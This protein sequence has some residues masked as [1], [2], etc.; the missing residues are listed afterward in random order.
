MSIV[1][2]S[3]FFEHFLRQADGQDLRRPVVL[4]LCYE[5]RQARAVYR[6][7]TGQRMPAPDAGPLPDGQE[8]AVVLVAEAAQVAPLLREHA[9]PGGA[10]A[11]ETLEEEEVASD[12]FGVILRRTGLEVGCFNR[13]GGGAG[14]AG[15]PA[16]GTP[17]RPEPPAS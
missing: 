9:G 13:Q 2:R 12:S 16:P 5:A 4:V 6:G 15:C 17:A 7:L 10:A 11:A 1:S 3:E 14:G 8:R